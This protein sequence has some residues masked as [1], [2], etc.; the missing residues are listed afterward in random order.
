MA[1]KTSAEPKTANQPLE[2]KIRMR[3]YQRYLERSGQDGSD[4]EDWLQAE[5]EIQEEE[6]DSAH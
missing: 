1:M 3:A 5:I 2:E 4:L 6:E